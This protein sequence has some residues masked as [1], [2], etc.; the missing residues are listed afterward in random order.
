MS[1]LVLKMGLQVNFDGELMEKCMEVR[2]CGNQCL[3]EQTPMSSTAF[4]LDF[5]LH[6][7]T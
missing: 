4:T 3:G 1:D 7:L 5:C 6:G 2:C